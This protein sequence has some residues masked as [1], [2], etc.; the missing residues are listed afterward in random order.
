M[1]APDK[2]P[3]PA[4]VMRDRRFIALLA[5][6]SVVGVICSLAAWG[7]LELNNELQSWV[8]DDL[9]SALGFDSRPVWWPVPVLALAGV[10]CALAITRLPGIGGHV[11][12]KGLNPATTLPIELP[13]VIAAALASIGLGMVLGPE[14]PLIALGGG[15]G[16]LAASRLRGILIRRSPP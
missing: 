7:F 11:P 14:A 8:Y 4:T 16:L 9:P 15:L 10:L 1:A 13:G 2:A 5:V 3:D 12:A 6:V